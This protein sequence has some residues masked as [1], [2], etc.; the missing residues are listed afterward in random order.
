MNFGNVLTA[1]V[2]PF[3]D[4]G[5][6]D[7]KQTEILI[8][9][10]LNNGTEGLVV[11]GTTGESPALTTEE[12]ISLFK[13]VVKVVNKRVPVIAGTG[14]N[15]TVSTITLTKE[16]EK[17]GVDAIMLV[18]PYY[19][20]PNQRGLYEHFAAIAKETTLPIMLYNIP[21]RSAVK[22]CAETI[23]NLSKIHNMVAV[24]EASGDL[25]QV[26]EIIQKTS[27]NFTVYSGDDGMTLPMLSIGAAG[28]VSVA[29]HIIGKEMQ[30]MVQAFWAGDV[31]EAA[32]LHRRLLPVMKGLFKFP[33]PAPV[34]AALH[35][36]GIAT[37]G[38]RLPLVALTKDEENEIKELVDG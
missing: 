5:N 8:E 7:Y 19:N 29:S 14:T 13:H 18:T 32:A 37:G 2:T 10:L 1:M 25:D 27:S 31:K 22:M 33:S 24:K 34:K 23:I 17:C 6:I 35:I 3:D 4:Q 16:A 15:N 26:A 20:K 21:G 12:K 9:Y 30:E 11:A 28:I 38:L 36:K